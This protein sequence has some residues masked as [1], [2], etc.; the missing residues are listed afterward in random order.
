V[1]LQKDNCERHFNYS[2]QTILMPVNFYMR[3][4][5]YPNMSCSHCLLL[6]KWLRLLGNGDIW[7]ISMDICGQVRMWPFISSYYHSFRI[8]KVK[9]YSPSMF[10]VLWKE[11]IAWFAYHER[12]HYWSEW[13]CCVQGI[14]IGGGWDQPGNGPPGRLTGCGSDPG[15]PVTAGT[16]RLPF[17]LFLHKWKLYETVLI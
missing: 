9:L 13:V 15:S 12:H 6:Q 5:S 16:G 14:G 17:A 10:T 3:T 7:D 4:E 1:F 11:S 2:Q 8:C